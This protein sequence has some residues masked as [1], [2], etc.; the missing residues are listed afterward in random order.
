MS[1]RLAARFALCVVGIAAALDASAESLP[2]PAASPS[3]PAG[4]TPAA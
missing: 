2:A 3:I 1:V 4:S